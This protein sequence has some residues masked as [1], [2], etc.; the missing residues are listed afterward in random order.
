MPLRSYANMEFDD[1]EKY[2]HVHATDGGVT[3]PSIPYFGAAD[4][5][6]PCGL[7]FYVTADDL[8]RLGAADGEPGHTTHFCAEGTVT[9]V[10][11]GLKG[12]RIEIEIE[13]LGASE[14]DMI[15][16]DQPGHICFTER[17]L[18]KMGL[19]CDCDLGDGIC[20]EGMAR[21]ESLSKSK[22]G[23]DEACLQITDLTFLGGDEDD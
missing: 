20:L 9:S 15:R 16:L 1:E 10:H 4:D 17:E 11:K 22:H 19:D 7:K 8:D 5:D 21:L 14:D 12:S 23:M 3:G 13:E 18:E 6:Y 2:D